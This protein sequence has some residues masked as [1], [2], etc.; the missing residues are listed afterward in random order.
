MLKNTK[1]YNGVIGITQSVR[2]LVW[3]RRY[4]K[5]ENYYE[6]SQPTLYILNYD[7]MMNCVNAAD[8]DLFM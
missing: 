5:F 4:E 7:E 3:L 6:V 8:A 1:K 2:P